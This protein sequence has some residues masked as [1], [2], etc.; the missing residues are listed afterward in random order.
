MQQKQAKSCTCLD[1]ITLCPCSSECL[2]LSVGLHAC[3]CLSAAGVL[4]VA[5]RPEGMLHVWHVVSTQQAASF[6]KPAR[7]RRIIA[8]TARM[9]DAARQG[10]L[11][12]AEAAW[13]RYFG[14]LEYDWR[15]I[16]QQPTLAAKAKR[17][18]AQLGPKQV[19]KQRL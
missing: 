12:R 1:V 8:L 19:L 18:L 13:C 7:P 17:S 6:R 16:S 14:S 10:V 5:Q 9:S 2:L 3:A 4:Q 11:E 15:G